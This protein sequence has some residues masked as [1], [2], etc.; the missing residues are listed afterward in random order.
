MTAAY[1]SV[2][3]LI[4]QRTGILLRDHRREDA[5]RLLRAQEWPPAALLAHLAQAPL[6]DARWQTITGGITIGETY[7]FRNEVQFNALQ[8][9]ILPRLIA[10]RRQE[11]H[12]VLR[13]WSAGCAT[14]EEP[15]TLALLLHDLLPDLPRWSITPQRNAARPA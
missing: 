10:Q 15:Y 8:K 9:T 14:G 4:E 7:F 1:E 5:L 2:L 12:L 13:C 11:G 6:T 3:S